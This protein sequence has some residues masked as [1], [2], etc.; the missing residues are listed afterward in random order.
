M[1]EDETVEQWLAIRKEAALKI[2]PDTAEVNWHYIQIL[3]P[4]GVRPDLPEE[5]D[6]F[7]RGFFARSPGSDVWVS[8]Y[9]LPENVVKALWKR[10]E[11]FPDGRPPSPWKAK[12]EETRAL[13]DEMK[14]P[15]AKAI[16]LRIAAE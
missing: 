6:C 14:D 1:R 7:G 4:Y 15:E 16:M 8:F 9:D 2:D 11:A 3:D 13:A 12:A 10:L 5:C